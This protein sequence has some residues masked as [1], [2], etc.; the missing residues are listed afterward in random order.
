MLSAEKK[1]LEHLTKYNEKFKEMGSLSHREGEWLKSYSFTLLNFMDLLDQL[2][3]VLHEKEAGLVDHINETAL[4]LKDLGDY[5]TAIDVLQRLSARCL[6]AK[7]FHQAGLS[8]NI[9]GTTYSQLNLFEHAEASFSWALRIF[10][11]QLNDLS[12][13]IRTLNNLGMC[14]IRTKRWQEAEKT[15]FEILKRVKKMPDTQ[16]TKSLDS[17][18]IGYIASIHQNLGQLYLN[19]AREAFDKEL[20][21]RNFAELS[22]RSINEAIQ[23]QTD[24]LKK[25]EAES[26]FA[27]AMYFLEQYLEAERLL[28]HLERKCLGEAAFTKL[29]TNI[30]RRQAMIKL[31]AGDVQDAMD[32]CYRALEIS[33]VFANPTEEMEVIETYI[34]ILRLSARILFEDIDDE[35]ERVKIASSR[36]YKLIDN[37]VEF[38]EKKD[39]YTGLHHSFNVCQLSVRMGEII[40]DNPSMFNTKTHSDDPENS[41]QID[42]LELAGMLHD[43]GKLQIPWAVINKILPLNEEEWLLIRQ[44]PINGFRIL[45]SFLLDEVGRIVIEHHEKVDGSGYP[46]NRTQISLMGAIVALADVYEAMTTINRLYRKAKPKDEALHEI[47]SLAGIHFDPRAVKAITMAMT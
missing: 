1:Y 3:L 35:I 7:N 11:K 17:P 15:F 37:L 2:P 4:L 13:T 22:C 33:L 34:D 38:L 44:H 19:M 12:G 40:R 23:F 8:F 47:N 29:L 31:V 6:S 28:K 25:M 14:L 41:V 21:H 42:L 46:R 26:D 10:Q 30:Y 36:G 24:P 20:P 16:I 5:F 27:E 32:Y 45:N 43:I 39:L 9:I 18:K